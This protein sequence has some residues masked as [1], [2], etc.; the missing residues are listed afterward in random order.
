[1]NKPSL[2]DE[3]NVPDKAIC[4]SFVGVDCGSFSGGVDKTKDPN[5]AI[6]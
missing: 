2:P 4:D 6:E 5:Q 1:V 3:L